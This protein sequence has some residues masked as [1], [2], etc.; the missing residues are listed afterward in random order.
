L[1]LVLAIAHVAAAEPRTCNENGRWRTDV[2]DVDGKV[3]RTE[4]GC[5]KTSQLDEVRGELARAP[6]KTTRADRLCRTA[7]PRCD[8]RMPTRPR[9]PIECVDDPLGSGCK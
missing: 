3:A 4:A 6:W 9:F 1:V 5:L 8:A 2:I 7:Q